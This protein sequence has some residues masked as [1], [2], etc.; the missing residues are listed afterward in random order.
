MFENCASAAATLGFSKK[1]VIVAQNSQPVFSNKMRES[2]VWPLLR[3][4]FKMGVDGGP[5]PPCPKSLS[6][7]A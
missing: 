6:F 3:E 7:V 1:W 4:A 2:H 5:T